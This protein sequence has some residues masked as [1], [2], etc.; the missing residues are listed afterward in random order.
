MPPKKTP[1]S[2]P[3]S[4]KMTRRDAIR[5]GIVGVFGASIIGDSST[6]E[7]IQESIELKLGKFTFIVPQNEFVPEEARI[8]IENIKD[9]YSKLE[10]YFGTETL[11]MNY[12]Q[13]VTFQNGAPGSLAIAGVTPATK[14]DK[15]IDNFNAETSINEDLKFC[16]EDVSDKLTVFHELF[17]LCIQWNMPTH[18]AAFIEGHARVFEDIFYPEEAEKIHEFDIAPELSTAINHG[19]WDIYGGMASDLIKTT[20]PHTINLYRILQRK[21]KMD[22]QELLKQDPDFLKKFYREIGEYKKIKDVDGLFDYTKLFDIGDKVSPVFKSWAMTQGKSMRI[23]FLGQRSEIV[24]VK[25]MKKDNSVYIINIGTRGKEP[26]LDESGELKYYTYG[27]S[28]VKIHTRAQDK[29]GVFTINF[30]GP[31]MHI[32]DEIPEG[33]IPITFEFDGMILPILEEGESL[34]ELE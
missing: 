33:E 32:F 6:Q 34:I 1:Q 7:K 11:M 29:D 4:E 25:K 23:P 14:I 26:E 31:H 15:V 21:W 28:Q 20:D 24:L 30:N 9:A 18:S 16:I 22:W 27:S 17:H 13:T 3:E 10:S 5:L 8:L 2:Q 19:N 12:P